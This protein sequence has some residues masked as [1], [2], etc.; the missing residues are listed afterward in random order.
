MKRQAGTSLHLLTREVRQIAKPLFDKNMMAFID[1]AS[2]WTTLAGSDLAVGTCPKCLK[3][4]RSN[5]T[6]GVLHIA[7]Q[8]GAF[9]L[10]LEHKKELILSRINTFFGFPAVR[11]LRVIQGAFKKEKPSEIRKKFELSENQRHEL[12]KTLAGIEDAELY[13]T[14]F[15][16][17]VERLKKTGL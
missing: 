17:G 1:L 13:D 16:I 15:Q 6:G 5:R 7:V 9:A 2:N 12:E 14:L 8:S 11:E 3:F 4:S 10:V